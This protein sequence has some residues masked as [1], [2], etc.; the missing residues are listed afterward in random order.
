[1]AWTTGLEPATSAVTGQRSNQ[2]SYVPKITLD[3]SVAVS[4]P[5]IR[6]CLPL[7]LVSLFFAVASSKLA[8]SATHE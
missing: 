1:M 7:V 5:A 3:R 2:L 4:N 8:K 6:S